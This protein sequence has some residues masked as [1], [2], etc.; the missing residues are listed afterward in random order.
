[1]K[2]F[3]SLFDNLNNLNNI[4]LIAFAPTESIV[5]STSI[6][7]VYSYYIEFNNEQYVLNNWP[8][9]FNNKKNIL[10]INDLHIFSNNNN[11][12]HINE[13]VFLI[14]Y[15]VTNV[16]HTFI[17]LLLQIQYYYNNHFNCKIMILK[18]TLEISNFIKS[19]INLFFDFDKIIILENNILYNIKKIK[20][21]FTGYTYPIEDANFEIKN[22]ELTDKIDYISYYDKFIHDNNDLNIFILNKIKNNIILEDFTEFADFNKICIIKSYDNM[23]NNSVNMNYN[24]SIQRSFKNEYLTFFEKKGFKILDPSSYTC[25]QLYFIFVF[26]LLCFEW[27]YRNPRFV[28]TFFLE[29]YNSIYFSM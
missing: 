22:I 27:K 28:L 13:E 16:G 5:H 15:E 7:S 12:I 9:L 8:F 20:I 10:D 18:Q 17:N 1:M 4:K 29:F 3:E 6:N 25:K 24:Y 11:I 14:K 26:G 23:N 21:L 19:I 2:H